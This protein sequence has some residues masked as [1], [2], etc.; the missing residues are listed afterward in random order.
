VKSDSELSHELTDTCDE[1]V[2]DDDEPVIVPWTSV[3]TPGDDK[4]QDPSAPPIHTYQQDETSGESLGSVDHDSQTNGKHW[5]RL[6][7]TTA[8]ADRQTDASST[9]TATSGAVSDSSS[10]QSSVRQ[11]TRSTQRRHPVRFN[12]YDVN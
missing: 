6:H 1:P 12:D 10:L 2:D 7:S 3:E 5:H 8:A 9:T 4:W 11:S